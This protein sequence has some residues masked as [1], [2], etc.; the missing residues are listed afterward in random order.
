[1][2]RDWDE[3]FAAWAAPPGQTEQD[4]CDNAVQAIRKAVSSSPSLSAR[5][6]I[7]IFP[8]GSYRNRTNVRAESDVDICVCCSGSV[9]FDIP[10]GTT[11]AQFS[12]T[13]PAPYSYEQFRADVGAA[14]MAHFGPSSVKQG[15]KAFD[16]HENTYRVSADAVPVFEYWNFLQLGAPPQRL[17]TGFHSGGN[18]IINYPEQHY[19]NGV[20]KN[21]ATGRRF[22]AIVRILKRLRFAL[23]DAGVVSAKGMASYAI[24]SMVWNVPSPRFGGATLRDD[25]RSVILYLSNE[26]EEGKASNTWTEVNGIKPLFGP[27]QPWTREQARDFLFHAWKYVELD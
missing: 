13:V 15:S 14:L 8:Q 19:A 17:G 22:K 5:T 7:Q 12:L 2:S 26:A 11:P 10:A 27:S 24:E 4:K 3:T 21:E 25:L 9:Y 18:R 16:I 20:A 1:M 23:S 6:D